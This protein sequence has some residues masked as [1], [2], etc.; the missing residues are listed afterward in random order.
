MG[1]NAEHALRIVNTLYN[2]SKRQKYTDF[3]ITAGNSKAFVHKPVICADSGFFDTICSGGASEVTLDRFESPKED[4]EVLT[5]TVRF[6]YLGVICL[7]NNI[8]FSVLHDAVHI[9]HKYLKRACEDYLISLL[10]VKNYQ[11]YSEKAE[12]FGLKTLS[13]AYHQL[14]RR[15]FSQLIKTESFLPSLSINDIVNYLKDDDL[16]VACEDDVLDAALRWLQK[17]KASDKKKEDYLETLIPHVR[18]SFCNRLKLK[19]LLK[20]QWVPVHVKV[21]IYEYLQDPR[22]FTPRSCYAES[23]IVI[24]GGHVQGN[25]A[26]DSIMYVGRQENQTITQAKLCHRSD[27]YSV[28]VHKERIIISGGYRLST[29]K[30]V[31]SVQQYSMKTRQWHELPDLLNPRCK[32]ASTCIDERLYI[33]AGCYIDYVK[34][35]T[36]TQKY[37]SLILM[38]SAGPR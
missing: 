26:T 37:T 38:L 34:T 23:K 9:K 35:S 5:Q 17:C 7:T 33:L 15:N 8:I 11:V 6:I 18:L 3:T 14:K 13:T 24:V 4:E 1:D 29:H 25:K 10:D 21:K 30:S 2:F 27:F 28:C 19:S 16:T 31:S 32:H 20:E 22:T 12:H 36:T